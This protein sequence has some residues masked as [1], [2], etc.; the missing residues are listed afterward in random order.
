M[1]AWSLYCRVEHRER[2]SETSLY[3]AGNNYLV[4]KQRLSDDDVDVLCEALIANTY[5]TALDLRYNNLTDVG[6][7]HIAQL[8]L[9][10]TWL[11]QQ[12]GN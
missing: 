5:V 7:K 2:K 10:W 8:L 11:L 4:S 6:A 9:V 3:L 12:W 1:S